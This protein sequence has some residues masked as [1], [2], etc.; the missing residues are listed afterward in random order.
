MHMSD[1][2]RT[3]VTAA[4]IAE[5]LRASGYRA[6]LVE[7]SGAPQIQSAAQGLGFYIGFGN[8]Q[9]GVADAYTDFAF[10]CVLGIE[11]ELAPGL[12]EGW[13][14]GMRFARL[15]RQQDLLVLS[16]DVIVAGGVSDAHLHAQI[17]L[18]DRLLRDFV[19]HLRG[20]DAPTAAEHA[21]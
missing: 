21:A 17:E 7:Q 10:H 3:T 5:A 18:W 9:A 16:M 2:V 8:A 11:G 13:N 1:T 19:R 12:I 14:R 6:N 4:A 20:N 15:F